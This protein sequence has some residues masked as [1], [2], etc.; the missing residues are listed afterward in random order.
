MDMAEQLKEAIAL[1][2]QISIFW[3]FVALLNVMIFLLKFQKRHS[4][5]ATR[6]W[7]ISGLAMNFFFAALYMP[8]LFLPEILNLLDVDLPIL[9]QFLMSYFFIVLLFATAA[10]SGTAIGMCALQRRKILM[11]E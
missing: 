5:K 6:I 9:I 8:Y 7:S 4:R 2:S 1:I 3:M 10:T 11:Q